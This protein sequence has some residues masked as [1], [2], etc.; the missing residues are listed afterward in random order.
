[1]YASSVERRHSSIAGALIL[2][3]GLFVGCA[4]E[5]QRTSILI[6]GA[7]LV[8]G[9][10]GTPSLGSLRFDE[11]LI[12]DV[13]Q[14]EPY[15]GETVVDAR[16]LALTPGFIDTHSHHDYGL[17]E[18][19]GALAAVSQGITTIVVGQDGGSNSPLR[20]FFPLLDSDPVAVNLASYSGHNSLRHAVMGEDFRRAATAAELDEMKQLL[21]DDLEA[22]ALG[23]AT[24]LEYDPGIY[25]EPAEVIELAKVASEYGGRYV[26]HVRSEDRSFWEAIEEILTIG[27]QAQLPVQISHIKL[28]MQAS[29]GE[30][31]RLL[32]RLDR[33]RAEGI[34]VTADIYP[35][36]YWLS[37]LEVMFPDRNFEDREAAHFAVYQLST[38]EGIIVPT[39]APDPS[40]ENRSLAD[41]AR[42][43][44]EEPEVTLTRLIAMARR[45]KSD[46]GEQEDVEEVMA[47][48]MDEADIEALMRWPH[49]N[50][51][52]DGRLRGSHPRGFGA[53]PRILGHYVRDRGV[54]SFEEAVQKAT[55]LPAT[56]MGLEK[57]GQLREG[58]AADL[59]LIDPEN[60][61]DRATIE[62]PHV[63]STGVEKVWVNGELVFNE[64]RITQAQPGRV[65]K[66]GRRGTIANGAK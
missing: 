51:C 1:M 37:T 59:A 39:F 55:A 2:I 41:I 30:S 52:T 32:A 53:Y 31:A 24:G 63:V 38:P 18:E 58:W 61:S 22:G 11:G 50:F 33:A 34:D 9:S 43:R 46:R 42:E 65:L 56:H 49:T 20:E 12:T 44:G 66:P 45:L 40:Y 13:G 25:S 3:G 5:P 21:R 8:D 62:S 4:D 28:A 14:L 19:P 54:L 29:I 35:Y 64:G 26:S 36:T 7:M 27:R 23:L 48:S 47:V 17:F 16:G 57:R 10:G 15:P 60:V 6:A